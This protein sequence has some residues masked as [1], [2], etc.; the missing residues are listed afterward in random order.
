M[1]NCFED[2]RTTIDDVDDY[3]PRLAFYHMCNI[4]VG[5]WNTV[6]RSKLEATALVI[7]VFKKD[8]FN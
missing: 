4:Q 1:C 3:T 5:S 8:I 7:A 2:W 6:N